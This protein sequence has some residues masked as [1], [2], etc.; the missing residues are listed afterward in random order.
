MIA[1]AKKPDKERAPL[2]LDRDRLAAASD[3]EQVRVQNILD[4]DR[5]QAE[6]EAERVKSKPF[7]CPDTPAVITDQHEQDRG[8]TTIIGAKK[9][10]RKLP[11][12]ERAYQKGKL[13]DRSRCTDA[14]ATDVEIER[15]LDRRDA[16]KRFMEAWLAAEA[17]I[18]G[19]SD[20]TRVRAVGVPGSFAD[21]QL[22]EK[23]FLRR[24]E[25][26]MSPNDW[27]IVR[28]V[29]GE[30]YPVIATILNVSP[31][32]RRSAWE[33]FR[34]ALDALVAAIGRNNG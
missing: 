7:Q 15:A 18:P 12:W 23:R 13:V 14:K 31:A 20:L 17:R 22:D 32:Y 10:W 21:H 30:D 19:S 26:R 24:C 11:N 27:I 4:R 29:C 25:E 1:R 3:A 33:R 16:C 9:G 8:L 34:E 5:A 28:R 6:A 2:P